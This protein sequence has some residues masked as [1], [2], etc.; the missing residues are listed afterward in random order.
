MSLL[1]PRDQPNLNALSIATCNLDILALNIKALGYELA[2]TLAAGLPAPPTTEPCRIGLRPKLATQAD[3]ESDWAGHWH[4]ELAIPRLYHRKGW[5]WSFLLQALHEANLLRHDARGLGFGCGGEPMASF[6]ASRDIATLITDLAPEDRRVAGWTAAGQH[7]ASLDHAYHPHLVDRARFDRL[8]RFRPMDMN[9]IHDDLAGFDFC[10]SLCAFEH[11]GSIEQGIDFV[12]RSLEPL[13]PGGLAVHTTE[14]NVNPLGPTIDNWPTV[15]FQQRHINGLVERLRARGH[16]VEA[17]DFDPG[18]GLLDR[19]VDLPPW[20][21]GTLELISRGLG[22][23]QHMKVAID[24]F[25]CTSIGL[26]IRKAD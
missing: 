5:E 3:I 9:A 6:F 19:F 26:I 16:H 15:M 7:A 1:N 21:D 24:G 12:E 23:P 20:R 2:R 4:A 13:R 8:V 14:F 25:V 22:E 10:W 11:L 18:N 17:V